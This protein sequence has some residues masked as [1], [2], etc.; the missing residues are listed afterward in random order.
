[1]RSDEKSNLWFQTEMEEGNMEDSYE[2]VG[3]NV[4]ECVPLAAILD[5]L[6]TRWL[7]EINECM[8]IRLLQLFK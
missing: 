6:L 1:M 2:K 3:K 8:F 5:F 4:L 7:S